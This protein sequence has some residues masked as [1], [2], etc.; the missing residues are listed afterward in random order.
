MR[1]RGKKVRESV[2]EAERTES[3]VP[4]LLGSVLS[5]V[6]L[7]L[8]SVIGRGVSLIWM[9]ADPLSFFFPCLPLVQ[10]CFVL[11]GACSL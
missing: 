10:D 2:E 8:L 3:N 6:F 5:F 9:S 7:I 11:V 4:W 1:E